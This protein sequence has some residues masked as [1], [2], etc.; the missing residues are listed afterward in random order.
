NG[1]GVIF[2]GSGSHTSDGNVVADN[3]IADSSDGYDV[4]SYWGGAVGRG[5]L[6]QSNCIYRAAKGA[7]SRPTTGFTAVGNLVARPRFVDAAR[8][9][10]GLLPGSPCLHVVGFD[11]ARPV[12]HA[13]HGKRHARSRHHVRPRRHARRRR[14]HPTRSS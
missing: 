1:Y 11:A 4:Q 13:A 7:I 5:N 12:A 2:A 3:V 8:H 10:Y 14:H 6:L 9:R